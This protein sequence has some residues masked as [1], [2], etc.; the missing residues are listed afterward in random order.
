[1][2]DCESVLSLYQEIQP[3]E[4]IEDASRSASKVQETGFTIAGVPYRHTAT[5]TSTHHCDMK[6]EEKVK[7]ELAKISRDCFDQTQT[8]YD[9]HA[10]TVSFFNFYTE[11]Y[12]LQ[13]ELVLQYVVACFASLGCDLR[14]MKSG[15]PLPGIQYSPVHGKLVRHLYRYLETKGL[16]EKHDEITSH[17]T[18]K[19]LSTRSTADLHAEMLERF[20][21][22][23]SETKLL[24]T[25]ASRLA[26]CLSGAADPLGLMFGDATARALME[27]VYTNAPMFK[28]RTLLLADYLSSTVERLGNSRKLRILELGAGTGGTTKNVIRKLAENN[29]AASFS[30][31]FTDLSSSLVGT[32]RRKLAKWPFM[33]YAVLDI[34]KDPAPE[35]TNAFDIIVSTNCIHATK[36]LVHSTTNI[37][38]MLRPDGVLCLVE[39]TRNLSW[40]D[41]V[42][43]LLEGWWLFNDGREHA[44]ADERQWG[45][46]L[47]AAGFD[48]VD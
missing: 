6:H 31:T 47:N 35:F 32:A 26:E 28:T 39:L 48:W 43:G 7:D 25:T 19:P 23:S 8:S 29:N 22:H 27:D 45:R 20:P 44:L 46:C 5:A 2:Q 30:Y 37:R 4:M 16:V 38:K 42:F 21:K 18:A 33:E 14:D 11:V 34:E 17:R 9:D 3:D 24:H 10:R 15:D 12:P 36:D 40:F 13:S 1:M 41:L